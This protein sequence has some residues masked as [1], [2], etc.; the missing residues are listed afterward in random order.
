M[1]I[2][3]L[4]ALFLEDCR[5]RRLREKT[6]EVY[7]YNLD[8]AMAWG[9]EATERSCKRHLADLADQGLSPFTCDQARRTLGT[10]FR[11]AFEERHLEH[12][13]MARLKKGRLP[14]HHVNRLDEDEVI[15]L[16]AL[17]GSTMQ[18][19]RDVAILAV[20]L[21]CGLRRGEVASLEINDVNLDTHLLH[22]R[23]GKGDKD[24]WVPIGHWVAVILEQYLQVRGREG[25]ALF[26]SRDGFPLASEGIAALVRRLKQ[27]LGRERLYSHLLRHSFAQLYW[28]KAGMERLRQVLG[29]ENIQTTQ[30]VYAEGDVDDL[31]K[32]HLEGGS[33]LDRLFVLRL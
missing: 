18:P 20:F 24:R 16:L 22:V 19:E 5:Y 26:L 12:N 32:T 27:R 21:D 6:V 29:H 28:P 3:E 25:R 13:P 2:S 23:G 8:R 4:V 33:P 7:R 30:K 10:F 14:K 9:L 17:A 31:V 11:F 1:N 15:Q